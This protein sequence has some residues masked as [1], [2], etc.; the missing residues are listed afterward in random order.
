MEEEVKLE[1]E[2]AEDGPPNLAQ[3]LA[4]FEGSPSSKQ[5][6]TWKQQHGEIFCTGFSETEF[7]VFRP[8]T[9]K[10]HKELTKKLSAP[11]Q[12]GEEPKTE[13]DL[14]ESV[15]DTCLLWT[16]V[17]NFHQKGGTI[18]AIFEAVM[19]NSNFVNPQIV[20]QFTIK[21]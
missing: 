9:W 14:Q 16:S 2:V 1:T 21:L 8:L 15:V 19:L 18:P 3:L 20:M 13:A 11:T 10:E 17:A 7:Y 12:E 6:E 4:K 5:I